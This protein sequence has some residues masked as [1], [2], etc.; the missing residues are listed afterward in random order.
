MPS[1][2]QEHVRS[3]MAHIYF[4][5]KVRLPRIKSIQI[6]NSLSHGTLTWIG[7]D[8]EYENL[9]CIYLDEIPLNFETKSPSV[10]TAR[11]PLDGMIGKMNKY[12][13][14]MWV[15]SDDKFKCYYSF[16]IRDTETKFPLI[17][18]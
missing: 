14:C 15:M 16:F 6:S 11:V 13:K 2:H 1:S 12:R 3:F 10:I 18:F 17:Y 7:C 8:F 4:T 5:C 9:R